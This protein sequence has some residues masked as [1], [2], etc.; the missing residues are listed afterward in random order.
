[1]VAHYDIPYVAVVNSLLTFAGL[2]LVRQAQLD[3]SDEQ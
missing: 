1:M 3:T 2:S